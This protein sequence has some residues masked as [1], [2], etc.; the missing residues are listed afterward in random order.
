[1]LSRQSSTQ[2]ANK[3]CVLV[4][5]LLIYALSKANLLFRETGGEVL[6]RLLVAV[7]LQF[8]DRNKEV[9]DEVV[10]VRTELVLN[11]SSSVVLSCCLLR[12]V[13]L[14]RV[15]VVRVL[16]LEVG[17]LGLRGVAFVCTAGE[18]IKSHCCSMVGYHVFS[19]Q[20]NALSAE[21][22]T[23]LHRKSQRANWERE[24]EGVEPLTRLSLAPIPACSARLLLVGSSSHRTLQIDTEGVG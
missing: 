22:L 5:C 13:E 6:E 12:V 14:L 21:H 2:P 11:V 15:R 23:T 17:R 19:I 7:L 8:V 1:M 20:R 18:T 16:E 10:S 3:S 9:T 24:G 4:C